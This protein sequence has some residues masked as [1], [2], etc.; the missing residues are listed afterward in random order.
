MSGLSPGQILEMPYVG[1]TLSML[2]FL[3]NQM[4]DS[5]TGLEKVGP[6]SVLLN[7]TAELNAY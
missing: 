5:T 6:S 3:P 7:M 4:E 1:G 2:I